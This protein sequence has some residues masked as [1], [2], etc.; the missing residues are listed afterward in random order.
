VPLS[1]YASRLPKLRMPK[2]KMPKVNRG[3]F[4]KP[5][6]RADAMNMVIKPVKPPV[7]KVQVTKPHYP[8]VHA[9]DLK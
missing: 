7:T 4:K 6:S 9:E 8:R 1:R 5:R 2:P 3:G